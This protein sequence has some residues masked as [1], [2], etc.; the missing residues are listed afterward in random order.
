MIRLDKLLSN[1]GYGSRKEIQYIAWSGAITHKG[2]ILK[3]VS[4]KVEP[5]DILIN[6]EKID[7]SKL[8]IVMNKPKGFICS[9]ND[10]AKLIYSLLPTRWQQRNPK[11][12][13][14]GRLDIDTSGVILLT[15]DGSLNH[16]LTTPKKN[17]TK[18]YEVELASALRGDEI[19]IFN[20][21]EMMLKG[22][23]KPCLPSKLTIKDSH[24]ATVELTEGR[25]HQVKRM[26][27]Y[28]GNRVVS[29]H[30]SG[31]A[32]IKVDDLKEGEFKIITYD[33][34]KL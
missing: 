32:N 7:A 10:S 20:S 12:S 28:V 15:D 4:T 24:H 8:I 27:G 33:D 5:E 23:S 22:E 30:R 3:D 21:G 26:F 29:L 34:I 2:K 17:I 11:I 13:T 14:I 18:I 19:E 1:L 16:A 31:F 6:D 9:H 25:Y